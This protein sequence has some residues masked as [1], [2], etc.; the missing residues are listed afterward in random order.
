MKSRFLISMRG[1]LV[2]IFP[3]LV[4]WLLVV[5][6]KLGGPCLGISG[7]S[8]HALKEF[9]HAGANALLIPRFSER[10]TVRRDLVVDSTPVDSH[11]G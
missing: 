2:F 10:F 4:I 5:E 1:V 11:D 9:R 7:V 3:C 6:S 8:G